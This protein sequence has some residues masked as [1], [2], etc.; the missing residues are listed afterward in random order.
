MLNKASIT[1]L[2]ALAQ[3]VAFEMHR[4]RSNAHTAKK[5]NKIFFLSSVRSGFLNG[6]V[7]NRRYKKQ[8]T[9]L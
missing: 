5:K 4:P 7:V 3:R 6:I 8:L 2:I 9:M 1:L